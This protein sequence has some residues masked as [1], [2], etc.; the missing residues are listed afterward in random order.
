MT[1]TTNTLIYVV[2]WDDAQ[3]VK[4]S[5]SWTKRL[6][7]LEKQAVKTFKD[8]GNAPA[9]SLKSAPQS[10][11][12]FL[13]SPYTAGF[14]AILKVAKSVFAAIAK[15]AKA[16]FKLVS[17]AI[18]DTIDDAK[19]FEDSLVL[20]RRTMSL[21]KED[22]K[23][24]GR[25]MLKLSTEIG[26]IKVDT[27]NEIAGIAGTLGL[28]GTQNIRTF[29]EA[30][31]KIDIATDL[32][33]AVA[34]ERIP[35]IL[36]IF[37]VATGNMGAATMD[38][39]NRLNLL[40]NTMNAT[41]SQ[42][43]T[44][45]QSMAPAAQAFGFTVDELLAVSAATA[46]VSTKMGTAGNA[47]VQVVTKMSTNYSKFAQ[48]LGIDSEEL[49]QTIETKPLEAIRMMVDSLN[50]I[51]ESQGPIAAQQA[52]SDLGFAGVKTNTFMQAMRATFDQVD[53]ALKQL[54]D[55]LAVNE[56]LDKET[57]IA[58]D[59]LTKQT[60]TFNNAI[61]NSQKLI[62]GPVVESM[63]KMLSEG[64]NPIVKQMFAWLEQSEFV[65]EIL[66]EM[67]EIANSV[68]QGILADLMAVVEGVDLEAFFQE[69]Y[70]G[71]LAAMDAIRNIDWTSVFSGI[72]TNISALKVSLTNTVDYL[73]GLDW[74]QIFFALQTALDVV[75]VSIAA[76]T[77]SVL[78]L[79][80]KYGELIQYMQTSEVWIR[81][82]D[83]IW[84]DLVETWDAL[85]LTA[86]TLSSA[87]SAVSNAMESYFEISEHFMAVTIEEGEK[88]GK[89]IGGYMPAQ[90]QLA[91]K[92]FQKLGDVVYGHSVLP[93]ILYHSE[94]VIDGIDRVGKAV[95]DSTKEFSKMGEAA[96]TIDETS[97]AMT[98]FQTQSGLTDRQLEHTKSILVQTQQAY[99]GT[100]GAMNGMTAAVG[101][102]SSAIDAAAMEENYRNLERAAK[103]LDRPHNQT[104]I[105]GEDNPFVDVSNNAQAQAAQNFVAQS[106]AESQKIAQALSQQQTISTAASQP[107]SSQ[108]T[109]RA[110]SR[111]PGPSTVSGMGGG[112]V[113]NINF[114][115][116]NIIDRTSQNSFIREVTRTQKV[117]G[118]MSFQG[119]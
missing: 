29:V 37:Q 30:I 16:A 4:G 76:F 117:Q 42:I 88:A 62:G 61:D 6:K 60:D 72:M 66:P 54:N 38:F 89:V 28:R 18:N 92:A 81:T 36:T 90:V 106:L 17:K 14:A 3:A 65:N 93:D 119:N 9:K 39:G 13:V 46:T 95:G 22:A 109:G 96:K 104:N 118:A 19:S 25:E 31:A 105:I 47:F 73:S 43:L 50:E 87:V 74:D 77:K 55:D 91:I 115:G 51:G 85:V 2:K 7:R 108:S 102:L 52:L 10:I 79:L 56:S 21:T 99:E 40:G 45:A 116:Q 70:V 97:D 33:A 15:L 58:M 48:V 71:F 68:F 67:G 24:L 5:D 23:E 113:T 59:T 83:I 41:Q 111:Q 49:K 101:N 86:E 26:G 107:A 98:E 100:T 1:T 110:E 114:S 12:K 94:L 78:W 103:I 82:F 34:A 20:A 112:Q 57:A 69:L 44:V 27:L 32:A 80:E 35:K 8:I 84:K 63:T 53:F 11:D 64:I 75:V